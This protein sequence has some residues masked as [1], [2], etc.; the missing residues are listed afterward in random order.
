[1]GGD[2][3]IW[4]RAV[5]NR[6]V[7]T[8]DIHDSTYIFTLAIHPCIVVNNPDSHSNLISLPQ[9]SLRVSARS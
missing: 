3:I 5:L 6:P 2:P 7:V 8:L 9:H 4:V 1:M